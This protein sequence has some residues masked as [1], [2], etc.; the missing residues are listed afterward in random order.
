MV[1]SLTRLNLSTSCGGKSLNRVY[2][3]PSQLSVQEVLL[4]YLLSCDL[5]DGEY[6]QYLFVRNS[7]Q[8]TA[9]VAV[10]SSI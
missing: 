9:K 4:R 5:T 7:S 10:L 2:R 3:H 6:K 8:I 1:P